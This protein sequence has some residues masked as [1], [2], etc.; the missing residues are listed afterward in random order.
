MNDHA[1]ARLNMVANQIRPNRVTDE[2]LID[3]M[4]E[5]PREL[6]VP[7]K[8]RGVAYIDEDIAVAPGRFL[9][10]PMV[11]ARLL[12]TADIREADVVLDVGCATGYSTAVVA[13]LAA[14]VVALESDARLAAEATRLLAELGVDNAAVATG[15]LN[16]GYPKQAPYD[17]IVLQG[18]VDEV[19][20][21]LRDQLGDGGR[22]LAVVS[23]DG[24]AGKATLM[25]K[26]HGTVS[27]RVV[28]DAAVPTLPGFAKAPRFVF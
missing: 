4:T 26:V 20:R 3:A 17:V 2:R 28:F 14:A 23:L 24:R 21:K 15:R 9:M 19:P 1:A 6:F 13:R 16:R 18:A 27:K 8:L 25:K 7:Q 22:L 12:Q 10:E 5:V 11:L